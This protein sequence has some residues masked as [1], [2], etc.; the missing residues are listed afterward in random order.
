MKTEMSSVIPRLSWLEG[1]D[2]LCSLTRPPPQK[3]PMIGSVLYWHHH[4]I[5]EFVNKGPTMLIFILYWFC[6]S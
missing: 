5:A 4:E 6:E 2:D 3:D 1:I